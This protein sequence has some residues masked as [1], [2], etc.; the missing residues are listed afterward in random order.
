MVRL[1]LALARCTDFAL[2]WFR[3]AWVRRSGSSPPIG[4]TMTGLPAAT[5]G[6]ATLLFR[7]VA[8]LAA[9][10]VS[11]EAGVWKAFVNTTILIVALLPGVGRGLVALYA[12]ARTQ[13]LVKGV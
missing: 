2:A 5:M 7:T 13:H 3:C 1:V 12:V 10:A 4:A 8:P 9:R 6:L 11:P